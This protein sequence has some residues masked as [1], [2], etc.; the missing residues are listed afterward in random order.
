VVFRFQNESNFYVLRDSA[1]GKNV[2]FYKVV[3]GVRSDPIGPEMDIA[4]N[5]WHTLAVQM[6][7]QSNHLL[8]GRQT[9]D[10]D[11]ARQFICHR[12]NRVLDEVRRRKSFRGHDHQLHAARAEGAGSCAGRIE[13][14]TT[15]SGAAPLHARRPG[16]PHVIASKLE[17]EIGQPGTDAEK[18]AVTDGTISFG[19]RP[20]HG[21]AH[22]AF[23]RSQRRSDR[24]GAGAVEIISGRDPGHRA[25]PRHDDCQNHPG[26][27][28]VREEL[29]Q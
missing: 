6:P 9:V 13:G 11:V 25:Y 1:L 27:D 22:V 3:N 16:R 15:H 29:T 14:T 17:K 4:T 26:A 12:Q 7:G 28:T 24:G 18:S 8:A 2:R 5:T 10:A 19:A 21:R 20:G 23:A